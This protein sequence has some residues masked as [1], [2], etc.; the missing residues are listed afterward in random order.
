MSR[1]ERRCKL[2]AFADK[3]ETN[4]EL[5]MAPVGAAGHRPA[6]VLFELLLGARGIEE[7]LEEA[8]GEAN[9]MTGCARRS[10]SADHCDQRRPNY[11]FFR[12]GF[13]EK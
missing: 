1:E 5:I 8:F 7:A 13:G 12:R 6:F 11:T 9:E 2:A 3:R 10:L 4:R